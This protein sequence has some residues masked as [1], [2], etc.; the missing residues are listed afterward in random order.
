MDAINF[1]ERLITARGAIFGMPEAVYRF[2]D[3]LIL[4]APDAPMFPEDVISV[5]AEAIHDFESDSAQVFVVDR[6][7]FLSDARFILQV[8]DSFVGEDFAGVVR[9]ACKEQFGWK[10]VKRVKILDR[11]LLGTIFKP[12]IITAIEWWTTL[13]QLSEEAE[14]EDETYTGFSVEQMF[15][16]RYQLANSIRSGLERND[17]IV[18]GWDYGDDSSLEN[19]LEYTGFDD[20]IIDDV[21]PKELMMHITENE[22]SVAEDCK[23]DYIT[24]WTAE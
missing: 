20:G 23:K 12:Y 22:I 13:L 21:V 10:P 3:Y 14:Y 8:I 24:I 11:E 1:K 5:I 18:L 9:K 16:V 2:A 7:Q 15:D 19:A 6:P 17:R 4:K